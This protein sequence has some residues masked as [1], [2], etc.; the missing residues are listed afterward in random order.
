MGLIMGLIS[1]V[2]TNLS[3][4]RLY[5]M[6][7]S[8]TLPCWHGPRLCYSSLADVKICQCDCWMHA[9][10]DRGDMSVLWWWHED[11]TCRVGQADKLCLA[12]PMLQHVTWS[13]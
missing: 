13:H 9:L 1:S 6:H 12:V 11:C 7:R 4:A 10:I 3:V 5:S 8:A 2:L